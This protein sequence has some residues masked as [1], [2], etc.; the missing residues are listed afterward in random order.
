MNYEA[1]DKIYVFGFSRGAVAAHALTGLISHSGLL[2]YDNLS[3][4]K[5]AWQYFIVDEHNI[6][7]VREKPR[8]TH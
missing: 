7:Y 1:G 6:E 4:T 2:R 8:I 3:Q 5:E